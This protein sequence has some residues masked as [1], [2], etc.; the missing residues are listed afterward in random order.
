[1]K[2]PTENSENTKKFI[3]L[4]LL[5]IVGRSYDATTTYLYTPDLTNESN[6]LV[7]FLGANWT[8]LIIIQ[9]ILTG[10][11]IGLLYFYFFIFS[12]I[13]P[14]EKN[15]TFRQFI[16][17][18]YFGNTTSFNKMFYKLPTNKNALFAS[19][20]Y[21]VS[22]TLIVTSY[23]VGTST[24]LLLLSDRYN[25]LYRQGIPTILYCI[26]LGLAIFFTVRFFKIEFKKYKSELG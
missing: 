21:I 12:P 13:T 5:V 20:G 1:M 18:F 2:N 8:A 16:S 14:T 22:M 15:L 4:S 3:L 7:E 23:I 6:I 26:I 10:L 11:T 9:I 24:T 19:I 17:H 25:Q